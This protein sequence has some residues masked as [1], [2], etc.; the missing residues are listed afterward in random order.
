MKYLLLAAF[1]LC[2][3]SHV[4]KIGRVGN[5]EFYKVQATSLLGPSVV[6]IVSMECGH[7][8]DV[9]MDQSF[10]GNGLAPAVIGSAGIVGGSVLWGNSFK[11]DRINVVAPVSIPE[12]D[13]PAELRPP[14]NVPPHKP[15]YSRVPDAW[16]KKKD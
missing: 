9:R 1:L 3:C 8:N 10:A 14:D 6:T 13:P 2:G 16:P 7:T 11:G 5:R 4:S 15:H 12:P